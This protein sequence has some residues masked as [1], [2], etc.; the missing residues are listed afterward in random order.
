VKYAGR[1]LSRRAS[2]QIDLLTGSSIQLWRLVHRPDGPDPFANGQNRATDAELDASLPR[3][4]AVITP[5]A[6]LEVI[7]GLCAGVQRLHHQLAKMG[8]ELP[9]DM[10]EAVETMIALARQEVRQG[11]PPG[12]AVYR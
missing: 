6:A 4:G 3:L 1:S 2:S 11:H 9:A 10:P 12:A 5:E 7:A 8:V